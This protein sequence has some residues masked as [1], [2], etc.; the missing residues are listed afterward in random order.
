MLMF[1]KKQEK[2]ETSI[3]DLKINLNNLI[4]QL[5]KASTIK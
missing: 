3:V 1:L 5:K 2:Y 4:I